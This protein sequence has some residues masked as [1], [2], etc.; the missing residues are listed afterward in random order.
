MVEKEYG[1]AKASGAHARTVEDFRTNRVLALLV[2]VGLL[3]LYGRQ[4]T[5]AWASRVFAGYRRAVPDA[6]EPAD[7]T[8]WPH[9]EVGRFHHTL[10]LFATAMAVVLA[11]A[12]TIRHHRP[13][14]VAVL[15]AAVLPH[16]LLGT[17]LLR[18]GTEVRGEQAAVLGW[19]PPRFLAAVKPARKRPGPT[20]LMS[21]DAE[22]PPADFPAAVRGLL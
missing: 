18:R 13:T 12:E 11:A 22:R 14:E 21:G 16:V 9:S 10:S 17:W 2:V 6:P 19:C 7:P 15:L 20:A 1:G 3:E 8:D 4:P 5:S